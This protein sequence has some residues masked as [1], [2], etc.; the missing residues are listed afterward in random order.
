MGGPE[1]SR[2]GVF[3]ILGR[4][5]ALLNAPERRYASGLLVLVLL[6]SVVDLLGLAA[7]I[8]VIGMVVE[9]ELLAS[10]AVMASLYDLAYGWGVVSEKRFLALLCGLLVAAFA[11][12]TVFGI[13]MNHVQSRFGFR[14]AHRLSGALWMHHFSDSLE[15]MRSKESGRVLTEINS[16]PVLFARVFVTGGQL[17]F[18]E[19]VVMILLAVGLTAYD[20]M[21]FL[22]VG[23]IVGVGALII[24]LVTRQR[25]RQ[26][27]AA[28]QRLAP[29]SSSIVQNAVRGFLE[30][31][32]FRAVGSVQ[33]TYLNRTRELYRVHSR[34]MVLGIVPTRLY[35]FLAVTA[36]CGIIVA[37]LWMGDSDSAFFETLSLLA[38]SAYRVMPAMSRINARLIAM[39]GQM[40]LLAAMEGAGEATEDAAREASAARETA[41]ATPT[42]P[43]AAATELKGPIRIDVKDLTLRYAASDGPVVEGLNFTF[44][45][46]ALTAITGP[47]GSGKSTLMS[48]LLGLHAPAAG[49]IEINGTALGPTLSPSQWLGSV[50][51]LSQHPFL[52]AGSVRDNLTLGTG[53]ATNDAEARDTESNDADT[54][55]A[56]GTI[57]LI[58]R[59][60]LGDVLGPDPLNF[61]L[62]EGGS[63]LSGGQQQRLALIRALR[64]E[65][66]VLILDE[67]TSGLDPAARDTVM[68]VLEAYAA[69]G[70]TVLLVTHDEA[71]AADRP[72]LRLAG[73]I[74]QTPTK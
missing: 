28:I 9:P 65:R 15:R 20:P 17:F 5:Y 50:A 13:W 49:S 63:N 24:R 56:D 43:T 71:A 26:N 73:N 59:L 51:Y 2:D 14:V 7:V 47:S 4:V 8:P 34:Q 48:A 39:R 18:N 69:A 54:F 72:Q 11:F 44:Q 10:N 6:N 36:L 42:G 16:W 53:G 61:Q 12:K 38:L 70:R 25:L 3:A 37:S 52:F 19:V 29:A 27:S 45:S 31:I 46:G 57:A 66:P 32:T 33:R 55:D 35:E 21:V 64:L 40:H 22:G 1:K 23:G 58:E 41:H 74:H 60:G 62:H 68:S 30:L 67:A